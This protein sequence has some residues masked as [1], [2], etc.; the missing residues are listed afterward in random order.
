M[1]AFTASAS[2]EGYRIPKSSP[3]RLE[4]PLLAALLEEAPQVESTVRL[5]R[6]NTY[7]I[8]FEEKA[9]TE[10]QFL[11]ADSNFFE[12]FNFKLISGNPAEVL[13]GPNKAVISENAAKKYF[14]YK[15]P[16]DTSPLGKVFVGGGTGE[17]TFE[18]TGIAENPPAQS[19]IQFDFVL[20]MEEM[21]RFT[22]ADLAKHWSLYL[23]QAEAGN[24]D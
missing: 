19:H 4:L 3:R 24:E 14:N 7:P 6:W 1:T 22:P 20:S 11:L 15:G 17:T 18:I 8:R 5:A 16:G 21:G 23:F 10:K 2:W 9:F 13:R 12:F